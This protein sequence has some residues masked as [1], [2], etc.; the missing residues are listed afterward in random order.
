MFRATLFLMVK[1]EYSLTGDTS[2][3]WMHPYNWMLQTKKEEDIYLLK[4]MNE[5]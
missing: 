1:S 3:A 2:S 5:A 4:I